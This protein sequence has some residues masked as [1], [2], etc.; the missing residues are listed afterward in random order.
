M[1]RV[2]MIDRTREGG[3]AMRLERRIARTRRTFL[4]ALAGDDQR[5]AI[6]EARLFPDRG[7][8]DV[9]LQRGA[10]PTHP[11]IGRRLG[12][13]PARASRAVASGTAEPVGVSN[14]IGAVGASSRAR[15]RA[16]PSSRQET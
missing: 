8:E 4:G 9:D 7:R 10:A 2:P 11:K 14:A 5:A 6:E 1:D 16:K 3:G 13:E 15:S 12:K